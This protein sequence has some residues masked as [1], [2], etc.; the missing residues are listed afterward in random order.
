MVLSEAV[1]ASPAPN[2]HAPGFSVTG[3]SQC[4]FGTYINYHKLDKKVWGK[5]SHLLGEDGNWQEAQMVAQLQRAGFKTRF[6]GDD[7]L[8]LIVGDAEIP[9]HPDGMIE[10]DV[11]EGGL[12]CKAMNTRRYTGFHKKR[13]ESEPSIKVQVQTYLS[14]LKK[15]FGIGGMWVY[16]KH[17]DS[18]NPSDFFE[19]FDYEYTMPIL[20]ATDEIILHGVIP[21]KEMKDMCSVCYHNI[22]CWGTPVVDMQNPNFLDDDDII[23]KWFKG[24]VWKDAGKSMYDDA[25]DELK[26]RLGNDEHLIISGMV[27]GK[28]VDSEED[29]APGGVQIKK[30]TKTKMS[31]NEVKFVKRFGAENLHL[32]LDKDKWDEKRTSKYRF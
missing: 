20:E 27:E 9:G 16:Y 10:V 5:G 4:S 32:V 14:E 29:M 19:P 26:A 7:Q 22:Y 18:C 8:E 3:I 11:K 31:F 23:A 28:Y 17:K 25:C 15:R 1:I 2:N 24:K 21:K 30:I 12:E 6:T 13:W